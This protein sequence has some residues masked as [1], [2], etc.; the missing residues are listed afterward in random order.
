[1]EEQ[2]IQELIHALMPDVGDLARDMAGGDPELSE[3]LPAEGYL[4]LV[5]AVRT[6]ASES[7]GD[8]V[9]DEEDLE[10]AVL[11]RVRESLERALAARE[12]L[13]LI[14]RHLVGQVEQLSGSIDRLTEELGTKPN[15]DEIANDMGISQERVLSILKLTGEDREDRSYFP[16]GQTD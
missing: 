15:I 14:D 12:D 1:M 6:L 7:Q 8:P 10:E 2:K 16:A 3:E 9:P 13:A 5:S 4:A 11:A